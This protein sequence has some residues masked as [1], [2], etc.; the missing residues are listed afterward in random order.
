[1]IIMR[2]RSLNVLVSTGFHLTDNVAWQL[3]SYVNISALVVHQIIRCNRTA[4]Q[5]REELKDLYRHKK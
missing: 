3:Q 4:D 1:M 2:G 5:T